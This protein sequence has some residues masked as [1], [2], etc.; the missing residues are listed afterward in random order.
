MSDDQQAASAVK[1]TVENLRAEAWALAQDYVMNQDPA[2]IE[3][4]R[5]LRDAADLLTWAA[6]GRPKPGYSLDWVS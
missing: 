5:A 1:A 6:E 4:V 3:R 2:T